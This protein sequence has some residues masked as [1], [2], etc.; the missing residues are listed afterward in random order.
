MGNTFL[1]SLMF[2]IIVRDIITQFHLLRMYNMWSDDGSL[3]IVLFVLFT[4]YYVG[5]TKSC[6]YWCRTHDLRYYCCHNGKSETW[7]DIMWPSFSIPWFW[8]NFGES[9]WH[10]LVHPSWEKKM[11]MKHCPPLRSHCPRSYD[12]YDL[13]MLCDD[14]DQCQNKEKCCYDV[15]LEHKTCKPAE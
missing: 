1:P 7:K 14:D 4:Y 2:I 5:E 11:K 12:W 8:F 9:H 3:K 15:C 10:P 13:P 6:R